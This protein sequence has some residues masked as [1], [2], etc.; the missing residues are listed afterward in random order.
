[1]M[2]ARWVYAGNLI[3]IRNKTILT[4]LNWLPITQQIKIAGVKVLHSIIVTKE[5]KDLFEILRIPRRKTAQIAM[6]KYPKKQKWTKS[7]IYQAVKSY[8]EL[9]DKYK[10]MDKEK[11][12][13]GVNTYAKA[14]YKKEPG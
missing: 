11:F 2:T 9:P 1:M 6:K 5:Q 7:M 3:R 4:K 12:K 8:N 14:K 10:M 13:T